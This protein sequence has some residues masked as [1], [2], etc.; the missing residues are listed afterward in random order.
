MVLHYKVKY[1]LGPLFKCEQALHVVYKGLNL[2]KIGHYLF[3]CS[4][5]SVII[6]SRLA[7]FIKSREEFAIR[8]FKFAS[9]NEMLSNQMNNACVCVS[10]NTFVKKQGSCHMECGII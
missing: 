8:F 6:V 1:I 7:Q 10:L 5:K 4:I 3:F 9:V 2:V